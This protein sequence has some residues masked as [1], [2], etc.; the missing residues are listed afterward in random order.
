[1]KYLR[2][3]S[4]N[5]IIDENAKILILGSMPSQKS[6]EEKTIYNENRKD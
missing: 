5:P 3:S 4:F 6:L 2:I 1:M